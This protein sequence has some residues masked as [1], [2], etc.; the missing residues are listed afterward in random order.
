MFILGFV[1]FRSGDWEK[2]STAVFGRLALKLKRADSFGFLP[3]PI[4]NDDL[5]K[6][7]KVDF[8]VIPAKAGIESRH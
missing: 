3:S 4:P 2:A 1:F 6:S 5:V 8:S 7:Q